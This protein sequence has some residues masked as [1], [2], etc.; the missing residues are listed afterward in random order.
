MFNQMED[1]AKGR[2]RL[3]LTM[4]LNCFT[5]IKHFIGNYPAA[6]SELKQ[7][8]GCDSIMMDHIRNGPLADWIPLNSQ[9]DAWDNDRFWK[10]MNEAL[11]LASEPATPMLDIKGNPRTP[12]RAQLGEGKKAATASRKE[13]NHPPSQLLEGSSAKSAPQHS[14][15]DRAQAHQRDSLPAPEMDSCNHT[16]KDSTPIN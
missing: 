4:L 5:A 9:C 3:I 7:I 8:A 11:S 16:R 6:V 12:A 1:L 2:Y 10:L 13:N 14:V 15:S